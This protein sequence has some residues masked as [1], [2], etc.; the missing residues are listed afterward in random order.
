MTEVS[1]VQ[2]LILS[3]TLINGAII[4]FVLVKQKEAT[5]HR[6]SI[7]DK[8]DTH[9]THLDACIDDLKYQV[10]GEAIKRSDFEHYKADINEA[11]TLMRATISNDTKGLHDRI[12]RIEN[13][14][15]GKQ[16]GD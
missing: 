4:P 3:V 9:M 10:V 1:I 11:L 6:A 14:F 13:Q 15:I 2:W 8:L 5:E 7:M 16:F 12:M